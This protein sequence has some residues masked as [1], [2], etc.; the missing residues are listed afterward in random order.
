MPPELW[1]DG[2]IDIAQRYNFYKEAADRIEQD[3]AKIMELR[4]DKQKL[5]DIIRELIDAIEW[6]DECYETY[7][8]LAESFIFREI[9]RS[10]AMEE[11]DQSNDSAEIDYHHALALARLA[12]EKEE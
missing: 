9:D 7:S 12:A 10:S 4:E 11:I 3:A 2:A 8:W 6:S 5:K 1:D